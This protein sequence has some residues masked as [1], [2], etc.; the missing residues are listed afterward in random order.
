[1]KEAKFGNE[2]YQLSFKFVKKVEM[3]KINSQKSK[4]AI[5]PLNFLNNLIKQFFNEMNYVEVGK[6]GK[7]VN[8][9]S[10]HVLA[11]TGIILFTGY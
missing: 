2:V 8:P 7:Y 3:Q 11:N 1:M 6:T 4:D 10:K 5:L 9:N